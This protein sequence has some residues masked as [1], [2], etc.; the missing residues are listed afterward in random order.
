VSAVD[1]STEGRAQA[2]SHVATLRRLG[3]Q[4]SNDWLALAGE[5]DDKPDVA[6]IERKAQ[7]EVMQVAKAEVARIKSGV[8]PVP[9]LSVRRY[10][11]IER[12]RLDWLW[13]GYIPFGKLTI[14][15]GDPKLGKS[16]LMLD[17]A[18]RVSRGHPMPFGSGL[19]VPA[20][21]LILSVE[22]DSGDT[23]GPRLDAAGADDTKVHEVKV[24]G[25][26]AFPDHI[27]LLREAITQTKAR[28]VIV[29]PF[30]AY[31]SGGCP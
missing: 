19:S 16:T 30:V 8:V 5:S 13:S 3:L 14:L 15:D 12:E 22:D 18:S 9:V 28:L 11:D 26:L 10:A 24:D 6:A 4:P 21:V 31:V 29:D 2:Q 7:A 20:D 25:V 1:I 17:I 27:D 23:I